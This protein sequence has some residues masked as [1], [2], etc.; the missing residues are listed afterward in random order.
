MSP[1]NLHIAGFSPTILK[2]ASSMVMSGVKRH[3]DL[4][5]GA[6]VKAP[7]ENNEFCEFWS[8]SP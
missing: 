1:S 3:I 5:R 6:G 8:M 2:V 7:K 4:T